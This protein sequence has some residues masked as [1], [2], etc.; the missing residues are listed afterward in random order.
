VVLAEQDAVAQK[1]EPGAAIHLPLDHLGLGVH[2]FGPAVMKRQG[3]SGDD[4]L[5]VQVQAAGEG[6]QMREAA[7]PGG[8]GLVLEPGLVGGVRP[9]QGGEGTSGPGT[10]DRAPHP[11]H[12]DPHHHRPA[13]SG[14][15]RDRP[16]AVPAHLAGPATASR[17]RHRPARRPRPDHDHAVQVR[18][19]VDDQG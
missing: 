13:I 12:P 11:P 7:G 17:A 10:R 4:G 16:L 8:L 19:I 9:E 5:G 1:S 6:V 18:H 3:D 2:A 14:H 15:V